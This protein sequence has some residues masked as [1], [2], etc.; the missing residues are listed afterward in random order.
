M[1]SVE[2]LIVV[3]GSDML[4]GVIL[5]WRIMVTEMTLQQ[6][7]ARVLLWYMQCKISIT[8]TLLT[9]GTQCYQG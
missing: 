6:R 4:P 5:M 8:I 9:S 7:I 3:L 1:T 2:V